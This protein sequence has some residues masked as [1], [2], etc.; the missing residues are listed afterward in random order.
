[1]NG[2]TIN[3]YMGSEDKVNVKDATQ[4]IK[5]QGPKGDPGQ[6]ENL[7]F[8]VLK[9]SRLPMQISPPNSCRH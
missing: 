4:I 3:I 7:A 9:V 8:L 1:M 2:N 5:L 6:R